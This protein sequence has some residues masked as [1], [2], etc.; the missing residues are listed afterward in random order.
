[1][2]T[3]IRTQHLIEQEHVDA[4]MME[5][6]ANVDDM[7]PELWPPILD[8]LLS[9]G[10]KDAWLTPIIMKKGRPAVMLQVLCTTSIQP[11]IESYIFQETT[12]LGLRYHNTRVHRLEKVKLSV[13]TQFGDIDVKLGYQ[14]GTLTQISPEFSQCQVAAGRT[15]PK[16][17]SSRP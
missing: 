14:A 5:I 15:C 12:T 1:M 7:N 4:E 17:F 11:K 13:P 8:G 10:A 3:K 2:A 9:L 6:C 16:S